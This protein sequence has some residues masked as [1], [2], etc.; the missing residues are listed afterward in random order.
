LIAILATIDNQNQVANDIEDQKA[1]FDSLVPKVKSLA[2]IYEKCSFVV[3][4]PSCFE[5]ATMLIE[6]NDALK[7]ELAMINKM[8]PGNSLQD[9]KTDK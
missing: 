6:W 7:K 8:A 1:K 2:E 3:K 4:D 5:E 9:L